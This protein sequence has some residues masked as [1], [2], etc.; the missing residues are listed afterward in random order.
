V[1]EFRVVILDDEAW[2]RD[3]IKRIGHWRELGFRIAGEAS[4]GASGLEC[5]RLLDPHLVITDMKMP[6][7]DG[8]QVLQELQRQHSKARII[9]I[10]GFS[11]YTY[12]RQ[13]VA[14]HAVD[15]LLKPVDP[16]EFNAVLQRCAEDLRTSRQEPGAAT[17][18][19]VLQGVDSQWLKDYQE[20]R[21]V[22]RHSLDSLSEP[23]LQEA[24]ERLRS[25]L[26]VCPTASRLP[27]L[28]K[29]SYELFSLL[30][31]QVILWLA[32]GDPRF[33]PALISCAV[34]EQTTVDEILDHYGALARDFMAL[35]ATESQR[36]HRVDIRPIRRYLETHYQDEITLDGLSKDFAISKEYL[37]SIFKKENGCTVTEY[38]TRIRLDKARDLITHYQLPLQ[39]I[40][41][42]VG[43]MD[44]PH[45]YRSFKRRF[46][47]APGAFREASKGKNPIEDNTSH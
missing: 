38:L 10:S 24:G 20:A 5:I 36:Q 4:D 11:D 35:R 28:V 21:D 8:I 25:L 15:Y 13:A 9:V 16:E 44:I 34:G 29:L 45:F 37:C 30:E 32:D 42:M 39:K 46:G 3:T 17:L 43:Y 23:G 33:Q 18:P 19:P 47:L 41:E 7:L 31:E 26:A 1:S 14:S 6:G 22:I 27:V 2:T 40:P 12:T